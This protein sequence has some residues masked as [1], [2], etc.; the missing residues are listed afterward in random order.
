MARHLLSHVVEYWL[1]RLRFHWIL[2]QNLTISWW[3]HQMETFPRY[4]S[5]VRGIHWWPVNSPHK[6]QWRG[7]LMFSLIC[8]WINGWVNK[9]GAGDLRRHHTHYDVT[10]MV[11]EMVQVMAVVVDVLSWHHAMNALC[12]LLSHSVGNPLDTAFFSQSGPEIYKI[13]VS[14][15]VNLNKLLNEKSSCWVFE[16]PWDLCYV[17]FQGQH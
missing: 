17:I 12:G 3:R 13:D 10:V 5:F 9:R 16:L 1:W 15:V 7:A 2:L 8:A 6:G 11:S 14:F 4:W